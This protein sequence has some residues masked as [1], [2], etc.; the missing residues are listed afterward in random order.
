MT[1]F[2]VYHSNQLDLL[3]TLISTL[4]ARDPLTD[5]FQK[6]VIL[7]QSSGMAQWLQVKLAEQFGVAANITFSLPAAFIWQM[8]TQVLPGIPKESAFSK[9]IM[10][11]KLMR[12]LPE[13]L[14][15]PAFAQLQNYL[16]ND[17]DKNKIYQLAARV[18]DLFDQYLIYRPKW[19]ESWQRG[20]LL[21]GLAK[22]QEWQAPLWVRLVQYTSEVA[23]QSEWHLAN[24]YNHF[25]SALDNAKD[26]PPGLPQRVFICGISAL[27]PAYIDALQAL[28]HHID[29]HLMF[30]NPCRYYW[31]D[32]QDYALLSRLQ[33]RKRRS[34]HQKQGQNLFR[35]PNQAVHL[36]NKEGQQQLGNPLLASWGKLG[37]DY[38]HLLSQLEGIQE[39]DAFV[40]IPDDNMLHAIQHDMLELEDH[41]VINIIQ[42][43][44][45]DRVTKRRLEPEDRSFRLHLCHSPLREVEV[46]H[47][48]VLS[49][50]EEDLELTL[51]DIIVMV[52][53]IEI[54]TPYIQAVFGNASS[55]CYLPFS[56]SDRRARQAHPVLQAFISL[57]DLPKSRFTAEQVL[58]FL[59]V[60]VVAA[61]FSFTEEGLSL[62][63]CWVSKS[64]IRWGLDDNNVR[65]LDLPVTGQHTWRFGITRM[66][67]GYAMES[68]AGDWQGILPYDEPSGLAAELVGQLADLLNK[69]TYWRQWLSET[70]SLEAWRPL[71]Q[72]L[73]NTFFSQ[74]GETKVVLALIEEQWEKLINFG[75]AARYQNSVPLSILRDDLIARLDQTRVNQ[76]FWLG[77]INFC[78]LMPMRSIPFKVVCLLGMNDGVYPRPLPQLGFDIMARQAHCGDRTR[79]DDDHYLFL[80]AILSA[81]KK[82]Y[83]SFIARS[84]QD[85]RERYPSVLVAALLE[86]LEQSYCLPGDEN[87]DSDI[88]AQRV[89]EHLLKWH[90]RTPFAVENF[91]PGSEQQSYAAE[92]L[93]VANRRG[94]APSSFS[95]PLPSTGKKEI[96]LDDLRRFYRHPIRAFFQLRLGVTFTL[97]KDELLKEEPFTL[98]YLSRYKLNSQLLHALIE[99]ENPNYLFQRACA[100]GN[101]PFGAF[102]KIY[103]Q[104]Q[105]EEM[106][107]LAK[108]VRAER[109]TDHSLELDI[110]IDG[111]HING[112]LHQVQGDG[113]LRW[114]PISLLAVDGI[115]LWLEHLVYCCAD[116]IGTSRLYG[117][118]STAWR[119]GA[120]TKENAQKHLAELIAGY[121]RGLRQPLLLLYR[122]GWAWLN[123]CYQPNIQKIDWKEETQTK[124]QSK[125]LQAWHGDH[126]MLGEKEDPY[127]QRV[128]CK[129]HLQ[130]D[131]LAQILSETERYL[132]PIVQHNVR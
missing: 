70:R 52:S 3:K 7:V 22:A 26:C 17:K 18:A 104:K 25:I 1:V 73:L 72:E 128:F 74:D 76:R 15:F 86:Y 65:E 77:R 117:R 14:T 62:L 110:N 13:F 108:K 57:L 102:G 48:Q 119:F 31:G 126:Y 111:V 42:E 101:L 46:L 121:Q 116:G 20:K 64:G 91:L 98:D 78:T 55:S 114:R 127:V 39:V 11:W 109:D 30:T 89:R 34:H 100:S 132:L 69:L 53:D 93:P 71:C 66:L 99:D 87:L 129:F 130:D 12:I 103:W 6:E 63:R 107:K 120:L 90:S 38:L 49:M 83:I 97:G 85:N 10:T 5:P 75:L 79:R 54:Y 124:A 113:L 44:L 115:L 36:F 24:L 125:L 95:Q 122:S 94:I 21:D 28:S 51:R 32:I 60:P 40:D 29:I 67:L 80:E 118:R 45:E 27:P 23:G 81:Q 123:Q 131:N 37:R 56:I 50:L 4:I 61:R 47:D 88:I 106:I 92:W 68:D 82:L 58:A 84:I 105:Q 2:T 16:T 41:A 112:W 33:S 96:S 59:E 35:E 19:L 8:F 9:D 43:R